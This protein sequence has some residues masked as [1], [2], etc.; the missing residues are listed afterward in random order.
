[1]KWFFKSKD[2][3]PESNVTGYWLVECKSLFSIVLLRFDKGSREAYHNHAFGAISWILSGYLR[4]D[5]IHSNIPRYLSPWIMPI[6]TSRMC[7]HKVTGLADKTWVLSFRGP[8]NKYWREYNKNTG[9]YTTLT[10]G[11]KVVN[12]QNSSNRQST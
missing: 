8:W 11:R 12:E 7:F 5:L 9:T 4:E 10:N 2:G 1:M 3:G 6:Y